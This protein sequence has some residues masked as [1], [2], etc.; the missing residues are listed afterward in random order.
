MDAEDP[1]V[2]AAA[3][4]AARHACFTARQPSPTCLAGVL[5]AEP[6]FV[7][8]E[9]DALRRTG[10]ADERDFAGAS[11]SL[12]ERWGDAALVAAAP[13]V[14]RTPK[15]EPASLLLVRSEAGW[16]LRAVYP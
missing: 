6:A 14:S 9:S 2:A 5:D 3:V 11:L 12:I 4:L 1:V 16:R 13:D 7:A 15:S 10:A 8:Q